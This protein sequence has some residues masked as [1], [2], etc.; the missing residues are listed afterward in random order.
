MGDMAA[1]TINIVT[2]NV[3]LIF[4]KRDA[5]SFEY[6]ARRCDQNGAIGRWPCTYDE[7]ANFAELLI[8]EGCRL[9]F[10]S[11]YSNSSSLLR[12]RRSMSHLKRLRRVP[13]MSAL[14]SGVS[15]S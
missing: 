1:A 2:G 12:G 11:N 13:G 15:D 8:R 4:R 6:A 14:S 7:I 9:S 5:C 10:K 3:V